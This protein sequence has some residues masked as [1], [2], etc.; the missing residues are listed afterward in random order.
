VKKVR[1]LSGEWTADAVILAMGSAYK[2]LDL[3]RED[4]LSARRVLVCH[5]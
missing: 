5:L 1:T 4:E 2:K 3:P